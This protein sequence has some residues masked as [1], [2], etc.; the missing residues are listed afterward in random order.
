MD[1]PECNGTGVVATEDMRLSN[2][3]YARFAEPDYIEIEVTC[4]E[5]HGS[6]EKEETDES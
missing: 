4:D 2:Q 3:N 1:C 6:G 5:C